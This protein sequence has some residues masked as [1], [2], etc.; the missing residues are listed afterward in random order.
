M[1][2][3]IGHLHSESAD[4]T[5]ALG[6]DLGEMLMP[7]DI[8]GL[9]GNLGAGKTQLVRGIADGAE[10]SADQVAS[11]TFSIVYPYQGR[12][13]LYHADFYRLKEERELEALGFD[14]FLDGKSVVVIEWFD[15]FWPDP[16][17]GHLRVTLSCVPGKDAERNISVEATGER[18]RVLADRWLKSQRTVTDRQLRVDRHQ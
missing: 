10:V 17:F 2:K 7:G 9:V 14:E 16:K 13:R 11:P 5:F 4:Q 18:S 1:G 8:V 6:R 3:S 12:V 15:Q